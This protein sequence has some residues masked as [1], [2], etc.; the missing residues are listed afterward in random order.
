MKDNRIVITGMGVMSAIGNNAGECLDALRHGRTGIGP[1][2]YLD[3]VHHEFPVGEVKLTCEH[4]ATRLAALIPATGIDLG[5]YP[6]TSLMGAIAASEAMRS[7]KLSTTD[8]AALLSGTTVGGMDKSERYFADAHHNPE[9]SKYIATHSCGAST[10]AIAQCFPGQFHLATTISTA[11]SSA[12]NTIIVGAE[13]LKSGRASVVVAGGSESLTRF[14]LNGFKSLMILDHEPCRP[15]DATRAGLN[16]GEGAAYLVLETESHAL[17]RGIEPLAVLSGTGN[18]C[19]AFHQTASSDN[20]EGAYQA[21]S[22]ALATAGL[23]PADIDYVNAHG[24]GTPNNDASECEALKRVFGTSVP[25][26]SSTKS[27]TGHTTSASGSIEA[28]FCV[29]ALRHQFLPVNL[30][31][32]APM[33]NGLKP[34]VDMEPSREIVNVQ[35]NAFGFGGNDSSI[36]ISKYQG[37][38]Q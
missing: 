25:P 21:M 12:L 6:R 22:R 23:E 14:H 4:M 17:A 2:R 35:C 20:G 11:C 32:H 8:K 37:H 26:F 24:T 7:A 9:H 13:L 15:F 33:D 28:A 1:M 38:E 3:S 36:I 30:N 27:F 34:V 5:S 16:L 10:E 29:M 18:R 19:D 31:W